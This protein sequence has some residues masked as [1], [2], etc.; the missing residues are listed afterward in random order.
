MTKSRTKYLQTKQGT[1]DCKNGVGL[2]VTPLNRGQM[3]CPF[4]GNE[5]RFI[6]YGLHKIRIIF[7][8]AYYLDSMDSGYFLSSKLRCFCGD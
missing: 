8:V 1:L 2:V 5:Y 6:T 4:R 3:D 7:V